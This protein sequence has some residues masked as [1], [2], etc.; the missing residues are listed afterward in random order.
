MPGV[1]Q[2]VSLHPQH[3]VPASCLDA[4]PLSY[5][6]VPFKE[7]GTNSSVCWR[8]V[9]WKVVLTYVQKCVLSRIMHI[10]LVGMHIGQ[11]TLFP[12]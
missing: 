11:V 4:Q 12:A 7:N 8:I 6:R 9:N 2:A 5:T 1:S 3:Q 10:G